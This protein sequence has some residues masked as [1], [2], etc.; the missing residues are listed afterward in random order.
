MRGPYKNR[1]TEYARA[2]ELRRS[3]YGY[4]S[5]ASQV[6]VPWRTVCGWVKHIPVDKRVAHEKAVARKKQENFPLAK[7]AVRMR[8]MEE[9]GDACQFCGLDRW[10]GEPIMLEMHRLNAG[11]D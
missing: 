3:G 2:I 10:L 9:R 7:S 11:R 6:N 1:L 4:R 5:I 8:L